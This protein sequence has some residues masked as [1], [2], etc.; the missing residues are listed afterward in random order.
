MARSKTSANAILYYEAGQDYQEMTELTDSGDQT[1]FTSGDSFWS[2]ASGKEPDVKP[3]G[4]ATGGTVTPADS[5][6]DDVVDVAA[7]TCYLAGT[8][9]EVSAST[10][11]SVTRPSAEDYKISSITV[12][13]SGTLAEV[14]GEEHTAFS[15]TRGGDGGP[16]YIP[17]G[18]IEIAQVR[19]T[20]TTSAA[21]AA[22]EIKQ[23]VGTHCERYDNPL[24]D[25]NYVDGEVD[26]YSAIPAI[27][28]G[29]EAKGVYAEYYTPVFAEIPNAYDYEPS[30]NSYSVSS[31]QVYGGTIGSTSESLS[32]G[33]FSVKAQDGIS[34]NFLS[35]KGDTRWFKF[36]QD[37]LVTDTYIADQGKLGISRSFPAGSGVQVDCTIAATEESTNVTP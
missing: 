6:T 31:E 19:M 20:S 15:S 34:D 36:L 37:R 17:V 9:N 33:S 35:A 28:T 25:I 12:D 2:S 18:S 30:E 13:S 29:D 26:F 1:N 14:E 21:I 5:G 23:V 22:S 4:L 10:D 7:L 24:F 16:P 11:F 27:H 32:A 8:L 3:D